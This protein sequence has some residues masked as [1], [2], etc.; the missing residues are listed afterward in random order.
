MGVVLWLT[1][2]PLD[3]YFAPA[4]GMLVQCLAVGVLV[5]AGGLVYALA[6]QLT[7]VMT[8]GMLRRSFARGA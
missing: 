2:Q 1:A 5:G 6:V 7:G 3:G 4:N 8:I